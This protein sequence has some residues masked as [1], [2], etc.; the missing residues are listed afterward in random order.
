MRSSQTREGICVPHIG[1][2]P[3]H[4]T[5]REVLFEYEDRVCLWSVSLAN[6][7]WDGYMDGEME[8]ERK[9]SSQVWKFLSEWKLPWKINVLLVKE[10][11]IITSLKGEVTYCPCRSGEERQVWSSRQWMNSHMWL[12]DPALLLFPIWHWPSPNR[13]AIKPSWTLSP[14][15]ENLTNSAPQ[16]TGS[17]GC[18]P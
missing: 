18:Q 15:D 8:E 1:K 5:A 3:T 16:L 4:C 17:W 12:P 7:L 10:W 6:W 14:K 11:C 2:I 13:A 9:N